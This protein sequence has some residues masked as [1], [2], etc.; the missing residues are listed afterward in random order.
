[1]TRLAL[2]KSSLVPW[3]MLILESN[4]AQD[5]EKSSAKI[6]RACLPPSATHGAKPHFS[7]SYLQGEIYVLANL[8]YLNILL[9]LYTQWYLMTVNLQQT[10]HSL[11]VS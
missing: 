1:M 6:Q 3:C 11:I 8:Y 7:T 10:Q 9:C 5:S 4:T 2:G